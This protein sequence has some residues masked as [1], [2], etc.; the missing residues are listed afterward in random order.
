[1]P[2]GLSS[3][4]RSSGFSLRGRRGS[5][6]PLVTVG[7]INESSMVNS[8]FHALWSAS[9]HSG[10][11]IEWFETFLASHYVQAPALSLHPQDKAPCRTNTSAPSSACL[12]PRARSQ[13]QLE[14]EEPTS[15]ITD[16]H[17]IRCSSLVLVWVSEIGKRVERMNLGKV[18][19]PIHAS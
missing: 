3:A 16:V 6:N 4:D 1:M 13:S 2:I 14:R 15:F 17:H 5:F 9:D 10:R 8:Q 11:I 18:A 12:S 19:P 7:N